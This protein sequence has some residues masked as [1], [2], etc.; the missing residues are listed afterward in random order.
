MDIRITVPYRADHFHIRVDSV[1]R[2]AEHL[3]QRVNM[4]P[5]RSD[6][7]LLCLCHHFVEYFQ[8][9]GRILGNTRVVRQKA[10]HFPFRIRDQREDHIHLVSLAGYRVYKTRLLA[11]GN[12]FRQNLRAGAVHG[13]RKVCRFLDA[14]DHPLQGLNFHFFRNRSTAVYICSSRFVLHPGTVLNKFRIPVGD[15]FRH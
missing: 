14:V 7:V 11:V 5:G 2:R 4:H 6:T 9:V 12:H 8:P 13:N 15:G 10:D 1:F 3:N